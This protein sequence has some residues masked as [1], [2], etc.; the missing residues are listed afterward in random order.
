MV[1]TS[2]LILHV[3]KNSDQSIKRI[4]RW[5]EGICEREAAKTN[6]I[7]LTRISFATWLFPLPGSPRIIITIWE[8]KQKAWSYP[9]KWKRLREMTWHWGGGGGLW[10]ALPSPAGSLCQAFSKCRPHSSSPASSQPVGGQG[11]G[12]VA[13]TGRARGAALRG[14]AFCRLDQRSS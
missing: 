2:A 9:L 8:E 6:V 1:L 13:V 5:G 4:S 14:T 10:R 12:A 3:R 11:V 7:T